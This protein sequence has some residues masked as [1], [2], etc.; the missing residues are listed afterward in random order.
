MECA[1]FESQPISLYLDIRFMF[2]F[3]INRMGTTD[4]VLCVKH[5][6]LSLYKTIHKEKVYKMYYRNKVVRFLFVLSITA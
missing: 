5:F 1:G 3:I 6:I 4:Q 2:F